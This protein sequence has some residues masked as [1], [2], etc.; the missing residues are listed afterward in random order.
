MLVMHQLSL[1]SIEAIKIVRNK[2][3]NMIGAF[4]T[5]ILN[6]ISFL[7]VEYPSN[8]KKSRVDLLEKFNGT[9]SKFQGFFN[10]VKFLIELQ[11]QSYPKSRSQVRFINIFL[12]DLALS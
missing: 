4:L 12:S 8:I 1:S 2:D 5:S 3:I 10:Q 11:F 7:I 9:R 6:H